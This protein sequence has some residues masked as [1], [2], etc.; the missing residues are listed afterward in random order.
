[1]LKLMPFPHVLDG[2]ETIPTSRRTNNCGRH[3]FTVAEN[4]T[5]T[6]SIGLQPQVECWYEQEKLPEACSSSPFPLQSKHHPVTS[7]F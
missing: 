2:K 7:H 6:D 5:K 3:M 1:M 4:H